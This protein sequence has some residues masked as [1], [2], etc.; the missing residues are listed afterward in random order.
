MTVVHIEGEMTVY[1]A[2][3]LKPLVLEPLETDAELQLDLSAVSELDT[4]GLQLLLL[5]RREALAHAGSC[6]LLAPSQA[7]A[8]VLAMLQLDELFSAVPTAAEP[9]PANGT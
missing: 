7:V 3:E 1:R 5:A 8:E 9:E 4:A 6:R 2:A